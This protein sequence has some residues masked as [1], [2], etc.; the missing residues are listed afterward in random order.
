MKKK[1]VNRAKR[2]VA[3]PRFRSAV[4][5]PAKGPGAYQ[6]KAKHPTKPDTQN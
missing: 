1:R 4:E 3:Q 6:R 5:K 2:A